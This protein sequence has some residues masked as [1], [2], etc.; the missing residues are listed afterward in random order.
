MGSSGEH[1]RLKFR[2]DGA[3][4][5][6]VAFRAGDFLAEIASPLDIVYNLEVDHWCGEERLRL[7]ILDFAPG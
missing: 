2:Q 6:G 1:L 7:G 5:D 3:I 4:W